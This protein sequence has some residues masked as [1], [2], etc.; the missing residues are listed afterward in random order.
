MRYRCIW[1]LCDEQGCEKV[2]VIEDETF[3]GL[4][5]QVEQK[6]K[7]TPLETHCRYEHTL[8][9]HVYEWIGDDR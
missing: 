3:D 2:G 7:D 6:R 4:M 5:E 8:T 9:F 1:H